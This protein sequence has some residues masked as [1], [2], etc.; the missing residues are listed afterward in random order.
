MN[1]SS[2]TKYLALVGLLYFLAA[3]FILYRYGI[4]L[5][6]EAEKYI[7]NARRILRHDELRNG[8]FGV[9]Y[10][11][12]SIIVA[13]FIQFSFNLA[14]VAVL[15]LLLSF[16]AALSLFYL[17]NSIFANRRLAFVFFLAYLLCY[18]IQKWNFY[19]YSESLHI[20]LLTIG[21]W[22]L[23]RA[24]QHKTIGAWL[25]FALLATA[26]LFSR[27]V[28][29]IFVLASVLVIIAG[30]YREGRK[31][32]AVAGLA[33]CMAGIV[34]LLYS[35]VTAFVNP[36]AIRRME[37]ICQVPQSGADT[38]YTEFN[39]AGLAKAFTVIRDEV[40]P[41]NFLKT[42]FRKLGAFFGLY[43]SYYSQASNA[44]LL[45]QFIFYPLALIGLWRRSPGTFYHTRLLASLYLLFTCLAIFVTCDDWANRF[46]A[47]LF[48]FILILA[49]GGVAALVKGKQA[50]FA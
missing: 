19:L 30:L 26:I 7:D 47:P 25:L 24:R 32:F 43:R 33:L 50:T 48:P 4:Q 27:P 8:V 29:V 49:A 5:G 31:G 12:Y 16:L 34:A 15:Q 14:G 38:S 1:N 36:D 42:G 46:I 11:S 45:L 21:T 9:F 17:L 10:F 44:L 37:V 35:P 41:G 2:A 23:Y 6:G 40:G 13:F 3:G 39:R 20:S 28:G 18:P 22:W